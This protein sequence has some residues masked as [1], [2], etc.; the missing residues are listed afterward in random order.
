MPIK[1]ILQ[2]TDGTRRVSS[3]V[4]ACGGLNRCLPFGNPD[5]DQG[6][7][8]S[9]PLFRHV[10]AYCDVLFNPSQMRLNPVDDTDGVDNCMEFGL[11]YFATCFRQ[12][13]LFLQYFR[14]SG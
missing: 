6:S 12:T 2:N 4:D 7:L 3:L 13:F 1:A 8:E 10:D 14:Q 11:R 9:F 5:T